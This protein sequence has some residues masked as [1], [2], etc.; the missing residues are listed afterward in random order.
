MNVDAAGSFAWISPWR[1]VSEHRD[2]LDPGI[3]GETLR[4][5]GTVVGDPGPTGGIGTDGA[6]PHRDAS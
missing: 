2:T 1:A 6:D 4:E 5:M 3:A